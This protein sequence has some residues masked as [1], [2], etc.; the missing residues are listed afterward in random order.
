VQKA[1]PEAHVIGDPRQPEELGRCHRNARLI[2]RAAVSLNAGSV[3]FAIATERH[4]GYAGTTSIG[5]ALWDVV[6]ASRARA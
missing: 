2:D 3:S 1:A 6:A 4:F 5:W